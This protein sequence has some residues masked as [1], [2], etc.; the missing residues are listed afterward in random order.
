MPY[1]SDADTYFNRPIRTYLDPI[2]HCRSCGMISTVRKEYV[3]FKGI[4]ICKGCEKDYNLNDE[5]VTRWI[6]AIINK[7]E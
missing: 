5:N 6:N 3:I 2:Y 1:I 7:P 4:L